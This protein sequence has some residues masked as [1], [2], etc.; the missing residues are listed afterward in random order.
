MAQKDLK[1]FAKGDPRI[2]RKGRPKAFD[3]IRKVAQEIAAEQVPSKAGE[4]RVRAAEI[5]RRW[6]I[7][8]N[9]QAQKAFLEYAYGKV[10]DK[11]EIDGAIII[12]PPKRADEAD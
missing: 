3:E 11:L 12:K 4:L 7:S 8:K 1:P 10:P 2:N 9:W 6:A 5:L